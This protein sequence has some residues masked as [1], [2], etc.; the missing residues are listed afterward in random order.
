MRI[1]QQIGWSQESKLIYQLVQ[2]TERVNQIL[3]GSQAGFNV[4]ISKQIGWSN[5]SSLYYQWL[6]SLSKLTSH[7]AD[8][9]A[10]TTTTTS[11]STSS[12]TTT[13]T[14]E[15]PVPIESQ[16][17]VNRFNPENRL[18]VWDICVDYSKNVTTIDYTT[19]GEASYRIASNATKLWSINAG[20]TNLTEFNIVASPFSGLTNSNFWQGPVG[21]NMQGACAKGDAITDTLVVSLNP[22]IGEVN[23]MVPY[24]SQLTYTI[25]VPPNGRSFTGSPIYVSELTGNYVISLNGDGITAIPYLSKYKYNG[26]G[27]VIFDID[28]SAYV[29]WID[30]QNC[31]IFSTTCSGVCAIYI[32][33]PIDGKVWKVDTTTLAI[34][35]SGYTLPSGVTSVSQLPSVVCNFV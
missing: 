8:C 16:L 35:D 3:P 14:T 13:T 33:N 15:F 2:Q 22:S 23:L 9:C 21:E 19:T 7:Y 5:E 31:S 18:D 10:P 26:S 6:L 4:P 11:T 32:F 34:T 17:L 1:S 25:V 28:I 24:S 27:T 30:L 12:T 20:G 29:P